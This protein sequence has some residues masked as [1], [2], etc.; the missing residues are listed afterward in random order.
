M[1]KRK[2]LNVENMLERFNT[3]LASN[4]PREAKI[5]IC[6]AIEIML[7]EANRYAGYRYLNTTYNAKTERYDVDPDTDYNRLYFFKKV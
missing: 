2:T 3:I 1:T 7:M 6:T 5:G 4:A